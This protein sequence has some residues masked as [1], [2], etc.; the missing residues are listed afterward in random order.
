MFNTGIVSLKN[1]KIKIK[2]KKQLYYNNKLIYQNS[3]SEINILNE[4]IENLVKVIDKTSKE[5]DEIHKKVS[6]FKHNIE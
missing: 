6:E 5:S 4:R 1:L 3:V 2:K